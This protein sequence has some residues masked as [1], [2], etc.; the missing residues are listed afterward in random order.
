M[1]VIPRSPQAGYKARDGVKTVQQIATLGWGSSSAKALQQLIEGNLEDR[2]RRAARAVAEGLRQD[3]GHDLLARHSSGWR[4]AAFFAHAGL[5]R[6]GRRVSA[7]RGDSARRG[8]VHTDWRRQ[9]PAE[10]V[11]NCTGRARRN[12]AAPAPVED[13][14]SPSRPP[15]S[16]ERALLH[17][18]PSRVFLCRA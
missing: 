16:L 18:R 7:R 12:P 13:S 17:R 8:S 5:V 11:S 4:S 3:G 10:S 14:S 15:V 9:V 2:P 1:R 6:M